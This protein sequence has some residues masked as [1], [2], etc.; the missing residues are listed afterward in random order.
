MIPDASLALYFAYLPTTLPKLVFS[1]TLWQYC[2]Y[3]VYC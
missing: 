3:S 1:A 2:Y